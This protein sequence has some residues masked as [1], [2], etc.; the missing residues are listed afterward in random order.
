MSKP[1]IPRE[2]LIDH[3]GS[4]RT[5]SLFRELNQSNLAPELTLKE[6][7]YEYKGRILPSLKLIYMSYE[8]PTEYQFAMD[9]FGYW[10]AWQKM[11]NSKLIW[12]HVVE[13][14]EELEVKLRST[15]ILSIYAA[16]TDSV[17]AAKYIAEKGW[18]KRAG[19]PTQAM[20]TKTAKVLSEVDKKIEEDA[21]RLGVH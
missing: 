10:K 16:S 18:D 19:R 9:V 8:E 15:A 2:T 6:Y 3:V 11:C 17:A 5:H 14:R 20:I 13:W 1:L 12:E 7:D 4:Y 21:E